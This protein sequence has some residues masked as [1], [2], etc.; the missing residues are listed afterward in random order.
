[1]AKASTNGFSNPFDVDVTKF[2]STMKIP[3]Y[4]FQALA[5]S[6]RK[7]FEALAAANKMALEGM[8]EIARRQSEIV[9]QGVEDISGAVSGLLSATTLEDRTVKNAEFAKTLY[10]KALANFWDLGEMVTK[11]NSR[12]FG[13]LNKRVADSLDEVKGIVNAPSSKAAA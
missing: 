13:V 9:S 5:T 6:Q 2:M 4:N 10:Q 7:N 12:T 11:S 3:S 1:M 8:Q